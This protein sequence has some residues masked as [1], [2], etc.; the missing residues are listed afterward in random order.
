MMKRDAV[1]LVNSKQLFKCDLLNVCIRMNKPRCVNMRL[2]RAT[3]DCLGIGGAGVADHN[4]KSIRR[5]IHL[6]RCVNANVVLC[7]SARMIT[8]GSCGSR[9][10]RVG[11]L[12]LELLDQYDIR[13]VVIMELL[14]FPVHGTTW[15]QRVNYLLRERVRA[16]HRIWFW[17]HGRK[18]FSLGSCSSRF[19]WHGSVLE[20]SETASLTT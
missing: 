3:V 1:A 7:T 13:I 10:P 19:K 17:R 2:Q 16:S 11:E 5:L 14:I 12:A 6:R 15:C 9:D 8:N 4:P 20:R 18:L